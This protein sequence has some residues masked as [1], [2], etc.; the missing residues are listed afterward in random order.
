[1]LK[2]KQVNLVGR[3]EVALVKC[4]PYTNIE[5]LHTPSCLSKGKYLSAGNT[6]T[7]N[8]FDGI[9]RPASERERESVFAFCTHFV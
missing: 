9:N 1:M 5:V 7:G 2:L 3:L 6:N 8:C 4:N